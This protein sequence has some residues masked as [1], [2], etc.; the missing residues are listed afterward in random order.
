MLLFFSCGE[1][2]TNVAGLLFALEGARLRKQLMIRQID[3]VHRNPVSGTVLTNERKNLDLYR[4]LASN[5]L[6][7]SI[8]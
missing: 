8:H 6:S 3:P 4:T 2:C 1:G 7:I 5:A